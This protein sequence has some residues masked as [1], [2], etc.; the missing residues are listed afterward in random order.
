VSVVGI[1]LSKPDEQS[2][3]GK[4]GASTHKVPRKRKE[5]R[6]DEDMGT[7]Q[8]TPKR[9][10]KSGRARTLSA[11]K[12]SFLET[13]VIIHKD[14][15]MESFGSKI[16]STLN[17]SD[18]QNPPPRRKE[19]SHPVMKGVSDDSTTGLPKG[20]EMSLSSSDATSTLS[21]ACGKRKAP[22]SPYFISLAV[23]PSSPPTTT[24]SSEKSLDKRSKISVIETWPMP[25]SLPHFRPTS[26]EEFGLIQEKL[27]YE[28]WK[29]LVAV[30]FLNVTTAKMALPLLG[31]LFE[32]WPTPEALSRGL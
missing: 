12:S 29:M 9:Q 27:C 28:P 18:S 32:R 11:I 7:M 24:T 25:S 17:T 26:P 31:Q 10:R 8:G 4:D 23:Q 16:N 21:S 13:S 30:I 3:L 5:R 19:K 20:E 1:L 14:I 6:R 15:S 22:T 2:T